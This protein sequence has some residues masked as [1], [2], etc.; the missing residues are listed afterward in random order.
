MSS[1]EKTVADTEEI[2]QNNVITKQN[3]INHEEGYEKWEEAEAEA[4]T[5]EYENRLHEYERAEQEERAKYIKWLEM[6][7][8]TS[9]DE[10]STDD[11][12]HSKHKN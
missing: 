10:S 6:T 5:K 3:N 11:E 7:H 12:S 9:G 8:V 4:H 1:D 2:Y